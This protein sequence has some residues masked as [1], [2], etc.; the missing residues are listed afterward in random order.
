MVQLE[1]HINGSVH[2]VEIAPW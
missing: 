1:L 2:M